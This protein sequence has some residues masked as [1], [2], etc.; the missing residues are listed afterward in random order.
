MV[1][2]FVY[3][4]L[5]RSLKILQISVMTLTVANFQPHRYHWSGTW[6]NTT[7]E[8]NMITLKV[9]NLTSI[10]ILFPTFIFVQHD[11]MTCFK[12]IL[13]SLISGLMFLGRG[14]NCRVYADWAGSSARSNRDEETPPGSP[15]VCRTAFLWTNESVWK[16]VTQCQKGETNLMTKGVYGHLNYFVALCCALERFLF[17]NEV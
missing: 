11:K 3:L 12:L 2:V 16:G 8:R 4:E 7:P 5:F 10:K 6:L 15:H 17:L 9:M 1:I 13:V 14:R